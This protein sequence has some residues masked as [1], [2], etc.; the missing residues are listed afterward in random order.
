MLQDSSCARRRRGSRGDLP[1]GVAGCDCDCAL[2]LMRCSTIVGPSGMLAISCRAW[3][4]LSMAAWMMDLRVRLSDGLR[5]R[6][7]SFR[8]HLAALKSSTSQH[9]GTLG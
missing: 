1:P 4:A 7:E 8:L 6:R 5:A 9:A 3:S 2:A